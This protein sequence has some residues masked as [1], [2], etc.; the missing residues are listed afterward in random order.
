MTSIT[1]RSAIVRSQDYS[2]VRRAARALLIATLLALSLASSASA[3]LYWSD[4]RGGVSHDRIGRADLDGTNRVDSWIGGTIQPSGLA[5]DDEHVYWTNG[6]TIGR[7]DHDGTNVDLGFVSGLGMGPNDV[8]VDDTYIYWSSWYP[9]AIGRARLDGS[10]ADPDFITNAGANPYAIAVDGQHVYW[11]NFNGQTIGRANLDGSDVDPAFLTARPGTSTTGVAIDDTYIYWSNYTGSAAP[12]N[13]IGR[14][15]LD[16][17]DVD[18]SF[19]TA[20]AGPTRIAVHDH[21]LYWVNVGTGAIA[22]ADV[23]GSGVDQHFVSGLLDPQGVAIDHEGPAFTSPATATTGMRVPFAFTVTTAGGAPAISASG[24]LP[25]GITFHDNGDGTATLSGQALVGTSGTYPITLTATDASGASTSQAFTLT[26][27]LAQSAPAITSAAA[28]TAPFGAPF[29]ALIRTTGFPI[30]TLTR[31]GALPAGVTFTDN[32]DG[33]ATLAGTPTGAALGIYPLTIKAKNTVGTATQAYTLTVTK[34]P[35]LTAVPTLTSY[36]GTAMTRTIKSKGWPTPAL[37]T[38]GTLPSGLTLTDNGDGTATLAGTPA[39]GTGGAYTVTVDATNS[40]G[41]DTLTFTL[42]VDEGPAFTSAASASAPEL[43]PFSFS[44]TATG[45][46]APTFTL[47]GTLPA[48]VV[49]HGSTGTFTGT[50]RIGTAGTYPL[51]LTA[52]NA[53]GTVTQAFVLTVSAS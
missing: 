12:D 26:V 28:G 41:A 47:A 38:S 7:A 3:S 52:R 48:G 1:Q 20:T 29:A 18:Q 8:A 10:E 46:P 11:A 45:Y 13:S 16:G 40:E 43:A 44:A 33:T 35:V 23:D 31:T 30:P 36:V 49:F 2:A 39:V 37:S 50:P 15:E 6:D 42:K 22:R 53:I 4:F 24:P 14:A 5:V 19:I 32:G 9:S 34:A 17:S 51:T 25:A 21:H 27:S